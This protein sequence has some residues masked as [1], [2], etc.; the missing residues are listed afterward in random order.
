MRTDSG[1]AEIVSANGVTDDLPRTTIGRNVQKWHLEEL[2]ED[3]DKTVKKLEKYLA[4]YLANPESLPSTRP[5]CKPWKG[6]K[7]CATDASGKVDAISYLESRRIKL[8]AHILEARESV[9][10]RDPESY[11]F[12]SYGTVDAAHAIAY[13]HRHASGRKGSKKNQAQESPITLAPRPHDL[14][15][16]NLPMTRA[17]RRNRMFWDGLWMTLLT[18]AFV[19]PNIATSV[20]LSDLSHLGQVWPGFQKN[21]E[22]H[23][24]GWGIAQ[25][26]IAPAVQS[27]FYLILPMIFRK[28]LT[29]SGDPSRTSRERHVT[30]RL[31]SFFVINQLIVFCIFAVVFRWVAAVVA[32]KDKN[33][34]EAMKEGHLFTQLMIGLCNVSTFWLTWQ[35]QHN[36][37]AATDLSQL[38]PVAWSWFKK[39]FTNPT[40]REIEELTKPQPFEYADYYNN[41][42]FCATVGLCFATLQPIIL[43]VT[44][45]YLLIE[46]WFKK[47]MLQYILFTKNESGGA[48]WRMIINRLLF[49]VVLSNAVIALVVGAQGVGAQDAVHNGSMLYAM[50][51][52]PFLLAGFKYYLLQSFDSKMGYTYPNPLLSTKDSATRSLSVDSE[53]KP[54]TPEAKINAKALSVRFGHPALYKPLIKPKVHR[55]A[56]HLLAEVLGHA[57]SENKSNVYGDEE[58]DDGRER[59]VMPYGESAIYMSPLKKKDRSSTAA[60]VAPYVE[61]SVASDVVDYAP[62]SNREAVNR[63]SE[64]ARDTTEGAYRDEEEGRTSVSTFATL[65]DAIRPGLE[66]LPFS[67]DVGGSGRRLY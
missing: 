4:K 67:T 49:A 35:M 27:I 36:L 51:P 45:F 48:F 29:H 15:W 53:G 28:I 46:V 40:V 34:W 3:H 52:L 56:Q 20:F 32:A 39:R 24:T 14:L 55:S 25:G 54:R 61:P 13:S 17:T 43:P 63:A 9:D 18:I 23:P 44:A 5:L 66:T 41:F 47:Y 50:I 1:I 57:I 59:P 2:M 62:G 10:K 30:S 58:V 12:A 42:L 19:V 60:L 8:A 65:D 37:S 7:D 38:L 21:L 16:Q 31:Y 64:S 6:D 11:G 33:V 22:A 26:I